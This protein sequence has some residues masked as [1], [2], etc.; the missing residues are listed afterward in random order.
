MNQRRYKQEYINIKYVCFPWKI[1]F[2][3]KFLYYTSCSMSITL[4]R[5]HISGNI[6]DYSFICQSVCF[7]CETSWPE[8]F[9]LG[10][11]NVRTMRNVQPP[12]SQGRNQGHWIQPTECDMID[13]RYFNLKV[14]QRKLWNSTVFLI[15]TCNFFVTHSQRIYEWNP[16][17]YF[18]NY[19]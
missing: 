5:K 13:Q 11:R 19:T 8:Y 16:F 4:K 17:W 7:N 2:F 12:G 3:A 9:I 14:I 6:K 1:A 18:M 10:M 15:E